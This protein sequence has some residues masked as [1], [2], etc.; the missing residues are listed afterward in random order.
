[1]RL[2]DEQGQQVIKS[3][4]CRWEEHD[5]RKLERG[6]D[7]TRMGT[8]AALQLRRERV[9]AQAPRQGVL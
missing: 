8:F 1:V 6:F 9:Q 7:S 2:L 3:P 4:R 5:V